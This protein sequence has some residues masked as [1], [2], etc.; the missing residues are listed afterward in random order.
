LIYVVVFVVVVV[1]VDVD[2]DVD[3][4]FSGADQRSVAES[5]ASER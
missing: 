2:V 3:N 5:S 1:V 4:G